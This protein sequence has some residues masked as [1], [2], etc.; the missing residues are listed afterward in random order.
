M[1]D[2][3]RP[4]TNC[5]MMPALLRTCDGRRPCGNS[6][7]PIG[8]NHRSMAVVPTDVSDLEVLEIAAHQWMDDPFARETWLIQRPEAY[9]HSQAELQRPEGSLHTSRAVA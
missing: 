3:H 8:C 7:I 6:S 2:Y 4:S 5:G 9:S 1:C